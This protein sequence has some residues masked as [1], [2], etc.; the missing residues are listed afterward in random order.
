VQIL[1]PHVVVT[2]VSETGLFLDALAKLQKATVS[3]VVSVRVEHLGPTGRSFIKFE[4]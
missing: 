2:A 3:L 1:T 4:I